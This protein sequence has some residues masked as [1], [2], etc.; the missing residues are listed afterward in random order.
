MTKRKIE[1]TPPERHEDE[2]SPSGEDSRPGSSKHEDW[3][4][5]EALA[6]TFPASDPI[7]PAHSPE[8]EEIERGRG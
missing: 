4:L 5:D 1:P 6:E 7:A 8:R 2:A 3:L